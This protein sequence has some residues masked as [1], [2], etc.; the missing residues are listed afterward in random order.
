MTLSLILGMAALGTVGIFVVISAQRE[1]IRVRF[2]HRESISPGQFTAMIADD[3]ITED[4]V[5]Q[6]LK[7][8][9]SIFGVDQ[10]KIRPD[11]R[12]DQEFA[13]S[14]VMKIDSPMS[15]FHLDVV[16]EAKRHGIDF[17]NMRIDTVRDY[18]SF[19]QS[20]KS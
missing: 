2:E 19:I 11:D 10:A 13:T 9:S 18:V 3:R 14:A 6:A 20:L 15:S 1:A 7:K 16:Y 5:R 17:R 4:S 8:L 12:F